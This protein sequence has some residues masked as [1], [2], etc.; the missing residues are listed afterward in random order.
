MT[1]DPARRGWLTGPV[2]ITGADGHVGRALRRRLAGAP[3]PVRP[4]TRSDDWASAIRDAD[5]VIHLAGTLQPRRP[6]TY[7]AA[8][9][10]TVERCV[11]ALRASTAR[12]VVV[13]SYVGA[14]PGSPNAHLRTKGQAERLVGD[15]ATTSV[16]LRSTFV[17][18][19]PDDVGPSFASYQTRPGGTVWVLGDGAQ[20]VAPI[21]VDDLVELLVV[22]ALDPAAPTGTFDVSGPTEYTLD[23]FVERINPA[24]VTIRHLPAAA[25]RRLAR[26]LPQLTPA[27][28]DVL[29]RDSV[30]EHDPHEIV[31]R[32]GVT[33]HDVAATTSEGMTT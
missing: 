12:R 18:G 22:V 23:A 15:A 24:D 17:Y 7:R 6:N 16:V 33:L 21:H 9:V 2:A 14:D 27:L 11:D 29:I 32:F 8:N 5:A 4:L 28:V 10:E 31:G 3:N 25:A 26:V 30:M 20:R 13:L 1:M 19:D